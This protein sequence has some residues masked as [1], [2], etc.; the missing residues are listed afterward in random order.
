MHMVILNNFLF[1]QLYWTIDLSRFLKNAVFKS[2]FIIKMNV[3]STI[4]F[5][6]IN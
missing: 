4:V 6:F 1:F 2:Q 3:T 5:D